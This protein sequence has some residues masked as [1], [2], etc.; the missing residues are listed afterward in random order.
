MLGTR[1]HLENGAILGSGVTGGVTNWGY[2]FEKVG[3]QN[4]GYRGTKS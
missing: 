3:L 1:L 2:I 4:W